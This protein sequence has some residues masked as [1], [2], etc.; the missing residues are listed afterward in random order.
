VHRLGRGG[1][2][3]R[4]LLPFGVVERAPLRA[5]VD[6]AFVDHEPA[7]IADE[8]SLISVLYDLARIALRAGKCLIRRLICRRLLTPAL[9]GGTLH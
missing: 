2:D 4:L 3:P 5:T 1:T 8:F 9:A 7:I 6:L